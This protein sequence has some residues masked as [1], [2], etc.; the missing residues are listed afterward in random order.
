M[1]ILS[2][3]FLVIVF[4]ICFI[5][6]EFYFFQKSKERFIDLKKAYKE[7]KEAKEDLHNLLKDN[8]I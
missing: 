7:F 5:R 3:T 4:L 8:D 6:L 1:N 2:Y